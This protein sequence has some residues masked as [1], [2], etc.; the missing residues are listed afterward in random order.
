MPVA[1]AAGIFLCQ[2]WNT[3]QLRVLKGA[4]DKISCIWYPTYIKKLQSFSSRQHAQIISV[5]DSR[6][7]LLTV[8][9]GQQ[10]DSAHINICRRNFV[11]CLM[12]RQGWPAVLYT[13]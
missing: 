1:L 11:V 2:A 3:D 8:K 4:I 7:D 10:N 12:R 5:F 6:D 13:V 9:S